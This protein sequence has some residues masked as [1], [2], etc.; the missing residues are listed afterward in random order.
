[1]NMMNIMDSPDFVK[2]THYTT[3]FTDVFGIP[4]V[5][6]KQKITFTHNGDRTVHRWSPYIQGFS[7]SF[8]NKT[9]SKY[10]ISTN[11]VVLDP[12]VGSGTVVISSKMRGIDSIGVDLNPLLIFMAEVKTRWDIDLKDVEYELNRLNWDQPPRI[13]PPEFLLTNKQFRAPVLTNLL[14]L[15][16]SLHEVESPHVRDLFRLAFSSIL[17]DCSNLKRSPCLGYDKK[18]K[19]PD[20]APFGYFRQK[21]SEMVEDLH[22]V[23]NRDWGAVHLINADARVVDYTQNEIPVLRNHTGIDIAI[24]SPPYVNG[25]D[26]VMNYKI[27]MA[28]LD[29]AT[30]QKDLRRLKEAM[31]VCDNVSRESIRVFSRQKNVYT[32]VWLDDIVDR[33][34]EKM[35]ERETYRRKDMHLIVKK[36]FNDLYPVFKNV[37][38]GLNEGGRFV[39]VIG[40]SLMADVYIPADLLIARMGMSIGFNI[41]EIQV[42]RKRRS[43]QRRDF[44]LRESVVVLRKG[45]ARRGQMMVG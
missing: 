19:V 35:I 11:H 1:M 17:T 27:E 29:F 28:W 32:D 33:I 12:F 7:A 21:V 37:Y 38:N 4:L 31:V 9:L 3:E 8:V 34:A 5:S 2:P 43:G 39:I 36:Y 10:K 23:Q 20:N 26:Y 40:D 24:T 45:E 16:Q 13:S 30:S 41:E 25:L 14:I 18:K 22:K 44:E 15:K 6:C 42:A